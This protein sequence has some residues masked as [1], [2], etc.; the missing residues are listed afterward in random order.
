[1]RDYKSHLC[2]FR[3][4]SSIQQ[5]LSMLSVRQLYY[6]RY[7]ILYLPFNFTPILTRNAF[8]VRE[9]M[10]GQVESTTSPFIAKN[11]NQTREVLE[12]SECIQIVR[13]RWE[14]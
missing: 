1:M 3:Y 12:P 9:F 11:E 10:N 13:V 7:R 6:T 4:K 8:T 14:S 2:D 5:S